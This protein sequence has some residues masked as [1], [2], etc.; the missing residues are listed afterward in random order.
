MRYA[1]WFLALIS[2][3][4]LLLC[5]VSGPSY[6]EPRIEIATDA[7]MP[8]IPGVKGTVLSTKSTSRG[9][10]KTISLKKVL[11]DTTK[12]VKKLEKNTA[13]LIKL[14]KK[15]KRTKQLPKPKLVTIKGS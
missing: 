7:G 14:L 9:T 2:S 12:K 15:L 1:N 3:I 4:L 13:E 10:P 6:A 5:T 11:K 8:A